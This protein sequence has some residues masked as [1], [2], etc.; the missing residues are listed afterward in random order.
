VTTSGL[1]G[2]GGGFTESLAPQDAELVLGGQTITRS[3]NTVSDVVAGV[4]LTLLR[5]DPATDVTLSVAK[6]ISGLTDKAKALVAGIND[7]LSTINKNMKWDVGSR[8]GEP[9]TGDSGARSLANELYRMVGNATGSGATKTLGQVGIT[10]NRD[11]SYAFDEAKFKTAVTT[12]ASGA[13]SLLSATSDA[14]AKYAVAATTETTTANGAK[15]R[16]AVLVGKESA[17]TDGKRI[18]KDMESWTTRLAL[19]EQVLRRQ[20]QSLD[21]AMNSMKN[22]SSWLAGQ[23]A[24]L[25]K[26]SSS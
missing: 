16:G 11:G 3:S 23:L 10:V 9:L 26:P 14:L 17:D 15:I 22:Q 6:D 8:R 24:G 20:F 13:A 12:D 2:F 18:Q 21:S 1:F 19:R 7:V 25:P 4:T 5:A